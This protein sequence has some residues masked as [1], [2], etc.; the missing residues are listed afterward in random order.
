ML[1]P[2]VSTSVQALNWAVC[3]MVGEDVVYLR[4]LLVPILRRR[5]CRTGCS[6]LGLP[7]HAG[8]AG[9]V[10]SSRLAI[11][12]LKRMKGNFTLNAKCA[13]PNLRGL[14]PHGTI[15]LPNLR[16]FCPHGTIPLYNL[17]IT[18]FKV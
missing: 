7:W 13:V 11:Y 12:H 8:L 6:V 16:G 9:Y 15:P 14:C 2:D 17:A 10:L 1:T 3:M 18:Y 4:E 5:Y